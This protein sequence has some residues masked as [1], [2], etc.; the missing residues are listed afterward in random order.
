MKMSKIIKPLIAVAIAAGVL[1]CAPAASAQLRWGATLGGLVT[2]LHFKQ[3]LVEVKQVPG[4]SAGVIG[5]VMFPGIGFGVDIGAQYEMRGAKVNL[6][7]KVMWSS[8]GYGDARF[9]EHYL[10]IPVHLRFKYTRLNGFEEY[11]API[12]F[13]GPSFGFLLGHSDIPAFQ[14]PVGEIGIDMGLG[15]EIF[16]R[17]QVTASFN[18]GMTYCTKANILTNYSAQNRTWKVAVT[19]FF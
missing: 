9:Y 4:F 18:L 6:G 12:V 14:F 17:W 11:L 19:Y 7:Q 10:A 16:K 15:A 3:P 2:G 5:E 13:A 8:Q 1:I